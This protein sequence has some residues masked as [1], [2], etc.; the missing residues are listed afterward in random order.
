MGIPSHLRCDQ[1]V[2]MVTDYLERALS[3]EEAVELEQHLLICG[4]CAAYVDQIRETIARAR[5]LL[6]AAKDAAPAD[7]AH[8]EVLLDTFRRWKGRSSP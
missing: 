8:S 7:D 1:V 2:E 4:G 5:G 3:H 6:P